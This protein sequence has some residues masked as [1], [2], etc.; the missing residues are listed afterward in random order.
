MKGNK[1]SKGEVDFPASPYYLITIMMIL[2]TIIKMLKTLIK[3]I[4]LSFQPDFG[5]WERS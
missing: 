4:I 5:G 1:T 2:S 3:F